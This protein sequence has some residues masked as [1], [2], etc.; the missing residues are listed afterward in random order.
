MLIADCPTCGGPLNPERQC[1]PHCHCKLSGKKRV[2]LIAA[3]AFLAA[4][5]GSE[6]VV[7]YGPALLP[8]MAGADQSVVTDLLA[9]PDAGDAGQP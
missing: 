3:A 6:P 2:A 4:C 9:P 8:D 1:C 7:E 5:G